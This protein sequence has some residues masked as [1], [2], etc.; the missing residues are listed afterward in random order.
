MVCATAV[1][2]PGLW[3]LTPSADEVP[4]LDLES[5][6]TKRLVLD[7]GPSKDE[8]TRILSQKSYSF[9]VETIAG[10]NRY[11]GTHTL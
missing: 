4:R 9:P 7:T 8:V 6:P 3:W 5:P 11:D 10:I 1:V 2:A